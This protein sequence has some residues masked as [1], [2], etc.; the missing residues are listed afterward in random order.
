MNLSL[1]DVRDV[2]RAYPK[3]VREGVLLDDVLAMFRLALLRHSENHWRDVE[4]TVDNQIRR[5][6]GMPLREKP[7][8]LDAE[9]AVRFVM[10]DELLAGV[11]AEP[12]LS[13]AEQTWRAHKAFLR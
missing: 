11:S 3:V 2:C 6:T 4:I 7:F 10:P 13:P 8:S 5:I 1:E 9:G 12:E